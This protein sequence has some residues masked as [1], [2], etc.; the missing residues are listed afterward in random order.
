[1][2]RIMTMDKF[3]E[4]LFFSRIYPRTSGKVRRLWGSLLPP[5]AARCLS[6]SSAQSRAAHQTRV[7]SCAAGWP[8]CVPVAARRHVDH[9]RVVDGQLLA[10][11]DA[12]ALREGGR[13]QLHRSNRTVQQAIKQTTAR[14]VLHVHA[15]TLFS[16]PPLRLSSAVNTSC[17]ARA[18]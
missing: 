15:S 17:Q 1:M 12:E 5:S 10:V 9:G 16:I 2:V 3:H 18:G 11:R 14:I 13:L 7:A 8:S 6:S 4:H